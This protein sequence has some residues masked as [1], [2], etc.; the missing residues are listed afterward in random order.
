MSNGRASANDMAKEQVG[1]LLEFVERKRKQ[2]RSVKARPRD[3][4]ECWS[5]PFMALGAAGADKPCNS[6][7]DAA[8]YI[9]GRRVDAQNLAPGDIIQVEG[10]A[11][12]TSKDNTRTLNF[13]HQHH[14][15]IVI[16]VDTPGADG[17]V[18][19][20]AHQWPGTPVRYDAIRLGSKTGSGT[21]HYYRPQSTK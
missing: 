21:L 18:V 13:P 9:W 4:G 2:R 8:L 17:P 20:V 14:S 15:M 12:L 3:R 5:L 6:C 11:T 1:I 16:E 7:G 10:A 19:K